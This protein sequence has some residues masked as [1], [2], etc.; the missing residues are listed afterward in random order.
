MIK[1]KGKSIEFKKFVFGRIVRDIDSGALMINSD[2]ELP[3]L[4]KIEPSKCFAIH[5]VSCEINR[6]VMDK[7]INTA[8][9]L[10]FN[11]GI[12]SLCNSKIYIIKVKNQIL[13]RRYVSITT[14][15]YFTSDYP[16]QYQDIDASIHDL[17]DFIFGEL[18]LTLPLP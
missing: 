10:I 5:P 11:A 6:T 14:L 16:E 7:S 1:F 15:G 9:V 13:L 4:S 12:N 2:F 18:I 8:H 3:E 17:D